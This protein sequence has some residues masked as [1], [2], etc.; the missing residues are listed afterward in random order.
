VPHDRP[1]SDTPIGGRED[2][3][4]TE[5]I[6]WEAKW[7]RKD[8]SDHLLIV[9]SPSNRDSVEEFIVVDPDSLRDLSEWR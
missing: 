1:S 7:T 3:A 6:E 2:P 4:E 5:H 8:R 9:P